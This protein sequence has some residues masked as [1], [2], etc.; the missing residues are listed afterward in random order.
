MDKI[1][2]VWKSVIWDNS[3]NA[4]KCVYEF[5][6]M[7]RIRSTRSEWLDPWSEEILP[8]KPV[9]VLTLSLVTTQ[10]SQLSF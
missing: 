7:Q 8:Q 9:S 6:D 5:I 3:M 1:W 4:K 2:E 10:K